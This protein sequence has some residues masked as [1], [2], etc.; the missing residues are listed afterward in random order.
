M[1]TNWSFLLDLN[2]INFALQEFYVK[3]YQMFDMHIPFYK[4]FK[5]KYPYWYNSE[6]IANI[7]KKAKLY[8]KFKKTVIYNYLQEVYEG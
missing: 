5:R 1:H 4:S 7:T 8:E 2:D 3:L 6:I